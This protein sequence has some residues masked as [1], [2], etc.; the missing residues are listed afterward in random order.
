MQF[1]APR[2]LAP[3]RLGMASALAAGLLGLLI[4]GGSR[5]SLSVR[6]WLH[7]RGLYQNDFLQIEM[8]PEPPP[9][10]K[11]GREGL[12]KAVMTRPGPPDRLRSALDRDLETLEKTLLQV[13]PWIESIDRIERSFPNHIRVRVRAYREP[14]AQVAARGQVAPIILDAKGIVLP[15]EDLDGQAAAPLLLIRGLLPPDVARPGLFL[16]LLVP[17]GVSSQDRSVAAS[18][19]LAG[20]LKPK[21][22]ASGREAPLFQVQAIQLRKGDLTLC[23]KTGDG[24]WIVWGEAP[25]D[26]TLGHATAS[27]KWTLLCEWFEGHKGR[28]VLAPQFL[29]VSVDRVELRGRG[30]DARPRSR[31]D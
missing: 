20:F 29:D 4:L 3:A 7:G 2:R 14:V 9:W 15:A 16:Q 11:P 1:R 28:P 22:R 12:L 21:L 31:E 23:L 5:A 13:S 27:R 18:A 30:P 17:E 25:G 6:Q 10:I 24:S 8:V 26:E 19:K